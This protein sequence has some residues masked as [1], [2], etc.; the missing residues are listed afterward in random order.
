MKWSSLIAL[1]LGLAVAV[2][3]A[4]ANNVAAIGRT[5]ALAG[6][7]V[8]AVVVAHFPGTFF[9]ARGWRSVIDEPLRPKVA[10]LFKFR[11]IKEAVNA[12][13]P[14]AQV[15]GEF[16]RARLLI[17][18]GA[19]LRGAAASCTVDAAAGVTGLFLYTLLGLAFFVVAPHDAAAAELA[20]RGVMVG[21]AIAIVVALAPRLGLLRLIEGGLKRLGAGKAWVGLGDIGGLHEAVM[22]LYRQPAKLWSC[23]GWHLLSWM[24]GTLETYVAL[25]VL[26]LH[27]TVAEAFI[28]DSLGQ[29]IRAAGF[30]VPG[31]LG[32]QEGG[33]ILV[34]GLF[35]IPP[36]K[37]LAF[38]FIRRIRE[39][40]L[41][42]P[43]LAVWAKMEG[44]T[45]KGVLSRKPA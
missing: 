9:A 44:W 34:C 36:D 29:G 30:A 10:R 5:L 37:A 22:A 20:G 19:S 31:A 38:S 45:L 7:G 43:G 23:T 8:G 14:V 16:A 6:W 28:I 4:L 17:R 3:L 25:T 13:L 2:A 24:A 12:L 11:W 42:V 32:V 40:I 41:G 33:Y 1:L 18:D 26:G 27:P 35:G 21:G 39:L 15:G